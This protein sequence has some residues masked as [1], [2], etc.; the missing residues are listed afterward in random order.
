MVIIQTVVLW[1]VPPFRADTD[2]SEEEWRCSSNMS[3]SSNSCF[4]DQKV[5]DV[6]ELQG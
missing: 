2:T 3:V 6:V 1:F 4:A 5:Y